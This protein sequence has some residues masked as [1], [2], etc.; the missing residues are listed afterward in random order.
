[1]RAS[2]D[3]PATPT[4][5]PGS[6]RRSAAA[7]AATSVVS[8]AAVTST[9]GAGT[10]TSAPISVTA[11]VV[12]LSAPADESHRA[13]LAQHLRPGLRRL[14]LIDW[15]TASIPP[16]IDTKSSLMSAIQSARLVLLLVTPDY[17]DD[18]GCRAAERAALARIPAGLRVVPVSVRPVTDWPTEPFGHLAHL[19]RED[20]GKPVTEYRSKDQAWA[21][22]ARDLLSLLGPRASR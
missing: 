17:L 9:S 21:D 6:S 20:G 22:V 18:P 19:P 2:V 8:G 13:R 14:G 15:H 3:A 10:S 16:G 11:D 5:T 4:T 1:M 7:P 12:Y